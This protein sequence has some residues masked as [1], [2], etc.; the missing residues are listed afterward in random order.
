MLEIAYEIQAKY[1]DTVRIHYTEKTSDGTIF[2]STLNRNPIQINIGQGQILQ[3]IESALVGMSVGESKS[4][5]VKADSAYGP[6]RKEM[7][8][9]IDRNQFPKH[10]VPIEGQVLQDHQPDG[11]IIDVKIA[12][13]TE[14]TVTLDANHPLAGKDLVYNIELVEII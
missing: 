12:Q 14:S 11:S 3:N 13:V 7:T 10:L 8:Q 2:S 6:Y 9:I 4:I 1:G 5:N